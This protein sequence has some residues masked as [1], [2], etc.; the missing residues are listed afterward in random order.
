MTILTKDD[1]RVADALDRIAALRALPIRTTRTQNE[2]LASLP[3]E[4]LLAVA[5][6]LRRHERTEQN[7]G[8]DSQ[9]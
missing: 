6:E 9:K 3:G 4:V 1:P 7:N 2:L 5:T 8:S